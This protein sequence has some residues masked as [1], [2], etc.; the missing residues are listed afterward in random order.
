MRLIFFIITFLILNNY[1]FGSDND[2]TQKYFKKGNIEFKVGK[3]SLFHYQNLLFIKVSDNEQDTT[4]KF[5]IEVPKSIKYAKNLYYE[6]YYYFYKEN[7]VIMILFDA[8]NNKLLNVKTDSIY[9]LNKDDIT[10][11][12]V[13]YLDK[14]YEKNNE[15]QYKFRN[16]NINRK[17]RIFRMYSIGEICFILFNIKRKNIEKYEKSIYSFR[18]LEKE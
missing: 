3:K 14:F 1:A 4:I 16:R 10:R 12:S 11:I 15:F 13:Y 17:K 6:R 5:A 9:N 18:E 2:T 8:I 7:Q